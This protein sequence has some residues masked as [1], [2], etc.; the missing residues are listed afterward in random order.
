MSEIRTFRCAF[1]LTKPRASHLQ[2]VSKNA[3]A[4]LHSTGSCKLEPGNGL[5]LT[6]AT[7]DCRRRR[8]LEG[9]SETDHSFNLIRQILKLA[10]QIFPYSSPKLFPAPGLVWIGPALVAVDNSSAADRSTHFRPTVSDPDGDITASRFGGRHRFGVCP[11]LR[12]PSAVQSTKR[13]G[14]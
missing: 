5:T 3:L 10:P 7:R 9:R 6:H 11:P 1:Q 12:P 2:F 8:P 13:S 14:S 4:V